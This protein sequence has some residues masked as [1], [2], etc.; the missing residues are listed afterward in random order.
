MAKLN[1]RAETSK[2]PMTF[3]AI[4]LWRSARRE[5]SLLD[6]NWHASVSTS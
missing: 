4:S 3:M 2:R 1:P 5:W 6:G